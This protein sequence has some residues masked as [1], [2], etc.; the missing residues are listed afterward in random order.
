MRR[1][2]KILNEVRTEKPSGKAGKT[3][4]TKIEAYY[5]DV[6]LGQPERGVPGVVSL[7]RI[8]NKRHLDYAV[9]IGDNNPSIHPTT[10]LDACRH[11]VRIYQNLKTESSGNS[12]H[13]LLINT[14]G[15]NL[16]LGASLTSKI[17]QFAGVTHAVHLR[18]DTRPDEIDVSKWEAA[19]AFPI[20]GITKGAAYSPFE[21]RFQR[22]AR[23][24]RASS[25]AK[26]ECMTP[27]KVAAQ[28][29]RLL[30]SIENR[31]TNPLQ[32]DDWLLDAFNASF[33]GICR[34]DPES[35]LYEFVALG[36]V[37]ATDRQG[38]S[39]Y[40]ITPLSP[41][42]LDESGAD[43]LLLGTQQVPLERWQQ[44]DSDAVKSSGDKPFFAFAGQIIDADISGKQN[45]KNLKRRRLLRPVAGP[46]P[47]AT[48][49]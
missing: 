13:M 37:R 25:L 31:E 6:D 34:L 11:L 35:L 36:L 41:T 14:H 2:G 20:E 7:T 5:L 1:L 12:Q 40:I 32:A 8:E 17:C 43:T 19:T 42:Q 22:F 48:S 15:W 49:R 44:G 38:E 29:M 28:D 24:F 23:Y 46:K 4:G 30:A 45:T 27:V 47:A 16:G 33:C 10:F 26:L 39:L 21:E 18:H 9:Y 3:A